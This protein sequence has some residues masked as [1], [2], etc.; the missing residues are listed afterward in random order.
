MSITTSPN[1][2]Y[3]IPGATSGDRRLADIQAVQTALTTIDEILAAEKISATTD[4]NAKNI[5][6]SGS[7]T[8]AK[9]ILPVTNLTSNIG[10]ALNQFKSINVETSNIS[11]DQAV[12]G[13]QS[14]GGDLTVN[15]NFTVNGQVTTV[16]STTVTTADNIIVVNK[17][18]VGYGVTAGAAGLE[19]DRGTAPAYQMVFDENIDM[20]CV[21]EIGSLETIA[22]QNYVNAQITQLTNLVAPQVNTTLDA[23]N[24]EIINRN[25][26]IA[27]EAT[28][29]N[30]AI[31]IAMGLVETQAALDATNKDNAVLAACA[32]LSHVGATGNAH[33]IVSTSA[34]GFASIADKIKLDGI[35]AGAQVN[36]VTSVAGRLGAITLTKSDVGLNF[37]DNTSDINKPVSVAQQLADTF[38]LNTSSTDASIK[39]NAAQSAAQLASVPIA[40]VG[41]VGNAHGVA[42]GVSSGFLSNTDKLKLDAITGSNT[43]DETNASIKSKL[44]ITVISGVNTGDQTNITGNAGTATVLQ[45]ARLI[46]GISFDGSSSI[47]INAVDSVPRVASSTLGAANGTATLDSSAIVPL[48]QLPAYIVNETTRAT[49]AEVNL[50]TLLTNEVNNRITAN[51]NEANVRASDIAAEVNNRITAITNEAAARVSDISTEVTNKKNAN[52]NLKA[53]IATEIANRTSADAALNL[54]VDNIISNTDAVALNSLSELVTA[55]QSADSNLTSTINNLSVTASS[56][57]ANETINRTLV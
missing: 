45:T 7:A 8:I 6:A 3:P 25:A 34:A 9:D 56:N 27:L 55:F 21:G 13:N 5:T 53:N 12:A 18:E 50:Q 24:N 37:V 15:G 43:G 33:G 38:V 28:A 41:S 52:N 42:T 57:V 47:V 40:H 10:T 23:I 2:G 39:A 20:F 11:G 51:T 54:R 30:A 48:N 36:T 17:G 4:L 46:N 35:A 44:G 29:R 16:N 1:N 49:A 14:V 19:V 31:S 26:A 22:S 32:L